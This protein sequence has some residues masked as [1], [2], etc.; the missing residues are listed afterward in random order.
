M[1]EQ[2]YGNG[3]EEADATLSEFD[4]RWEK[5]E[6]WM[7]LSLFE[8]RETLSKKV[9]ALAGKPLSRCVVGRAMNTARPVV[10]RW[11]LRAYSVEKLG[12]RP[13]DDG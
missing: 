10:L 7:I 9:I 3:K 1:A 11:P 8:A 2:T 12:E 4:M 13:I 5:V 6:G